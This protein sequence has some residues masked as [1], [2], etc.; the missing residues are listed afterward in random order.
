[1]ALL[2][3]LPPPSLTSVSCGQLR[4][5][6]WGSV[7]MHVQA[8]L[9]LHSSSWDQLVSVVKA[10]SGAAVFVRSGGHELAG[11]PMPH[12]LPSRGTV[13]IGGQTRW[14]FSWLAAPNVRVYVVAPAA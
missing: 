1:V 4:A 3:P 8:R 2:T 13:R 7:A 14:V 6:S 5:D 12:H 11:G 10:T 9:A